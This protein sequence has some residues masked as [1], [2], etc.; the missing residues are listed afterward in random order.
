MILNNNLLHQII[1]AWF[2]INIYYIKSL[3]YDIISE[4]F[5]SVNN[6]KNDKNKLNHFFYKRRPIHNRTEIGLWIQE[7][8]RCGFKIALIR[9]FIFK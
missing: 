7:N 5:I 9:Y 8:R 6:K 4:N 2:E 1:N 3:T